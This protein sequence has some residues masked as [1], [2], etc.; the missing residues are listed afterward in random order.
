MV[1]RDGPRARQRRLHRG[2]GG[3]QAGAA[4]SGDPR[5]PRAGARRWTSRRVNVKASTGERIGL[6][7]PRRGRRGARGREPSRALAE[8]ARATLGLR[9]DAR[10]PPARH[11]QRRAPAARPARS[12]PR[13]HLRVRADRLQPH[14][15]RQRAPVR[16]LQPAAALPRARGLRGEPR[17]QRH[18]R[19]R[20]D[21]RRRARAGTPQRGARRGDDRALHR[22]HRRASASAAPTTSRSRPRRSGRSSSTSPTLIE[23]GH[24]YAADGDVYFR[25]RSDEGYGSL[26]HRRLENMDQGEGI[27][28][29]RAQGGPAGLRAVEGA[30]GG[31]GHV[32]GLALGAGPPR[33]AHRVLGDGRAAARRRLR[34]PRR[35]L[36]PR[37]PPPR[38]RGRADARGARRGADETVDAQRHDPVHRREDGQVGRQH[39]AAARGARRA[40]SATRS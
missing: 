8:R 40:R 17:D 37:L 13:R 24:A 32:V 15:H 14:P 38:E 30:Q 26:S 10:D 20:Q 35:R 25:V 12:R 7:R 9:G 19:Q 3:A 2:H 6:R 39:R 28:G 31:R 5:A 36:G 4:P 29:T 33:L 23:R 16:R 22:R 27:E 18:R 11:A 1:A 21:L 34:H